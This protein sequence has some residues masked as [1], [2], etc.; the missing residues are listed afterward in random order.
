M[1][2]GN[3]KQLV[4]GAMAFLAVFLV[5]MGLEFRGFFRLLDPAITGGIQRLIPRT[6]D[7]PLSLFSILGSAEVTILILVGIFFYVLIRERKIFW[8]L[9]LFLVL[10]GFELLGKFV[11]YHPGPPKI[12]FRYALPFS[13]PEYVNAPYSFPSG[14]VSRT[15]FLVLVAIFLINRK[16]SNR[17]T[18][19]LLVLGLVIAAVVMMV[20][21]IYLG[22]HWTSD[23]FGGAF[24]GTA[25]GLLAMVY[26]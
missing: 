24:L 14:H 21:R 9:G 12:F 20:S 23:V 5:L 7:V 6:F 10:T 1:L 4:V 13:T 19:Q 16:I 3:R 25:M 2:K 18:R 22:E 8:T 26:Y 17:L 15:V 11:L